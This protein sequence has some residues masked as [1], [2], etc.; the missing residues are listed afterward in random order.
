MYCTLMSSAHLRHSAIATS[1]TNEDLLNWMV[2]VFPSLWLPFIKLWTATLH[3][4]MASLSF[5]IS[6]VGQK[7]GNQ[8]KF[9]LYN[10][11]MSIIVS[12]KNLIMWFTHF[13]FHKGT[14]KHWIYDM[15]H[16]SVFCYVQTMGF[17]VTYTCSSM[18]S[19]AHTVLER[20]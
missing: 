7:V 13:I 12:V 16:S 19:T 10:L 9:D 2:L 20:A 11:L 5:C 6:F 8:C 1:N 4:V 17:L 3:I 14:L 18:F 15:C